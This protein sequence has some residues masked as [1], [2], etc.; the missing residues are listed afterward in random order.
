[1]RKYMYLITT[2]ILLLMIYVATPYIMNALGNK[3]V[4]INKNHKILIIGHRGGAGMAV[5]NTLQCIEKGIQT[6][7]DMIEVD[8][9]MTKDGELVVCHD[10]TIDRTTNGTGRI[11]EM[12]LAEIKK[13]NI[14]DT[15]GNTI[16]EK[17]PTLNEVLEQINGKCKLLIEIKRTH[18]L[19]LG[20]EAKLLSVIKNHNASEWTV[21]QSFNDTVL[22]T[23]HTLDKTVRL[24]K[25]IVFKFQWL[26]IIFDGT[27]TTFNLKK[28]HYISSFNFHYR[29]VTSSLIQELHTHGKE[30]KIW[31]LEEPNKQSLPPVD[32][33]I[34]NRP[35]LW[36]S[37]IKFKS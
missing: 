31:T 17:I 35:D 28:Y 1:M 22:K 2:F 27:F 15:E 36:V 11:A 9:H 10:Q 21:I 18:N 12:T 3:R 5:E 19:Y 13:F 30:I 4:S 20:I 26:P 34:T 23:L 16:K 29:A 6:G 24:E 8:V 14:V 33:I 37:F 32:G 25:L 7:A